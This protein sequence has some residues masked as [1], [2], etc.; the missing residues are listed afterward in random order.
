MNDVTDLETDVL[1][2]GGC[3]GDGSPGRALKSTREGR[4]G[5]VA[6]DDSADHGP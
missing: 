2:P 3:T 6:I 1:S 4:I 5:D